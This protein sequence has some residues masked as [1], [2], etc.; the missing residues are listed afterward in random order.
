MEY[1]MM[2]EEMLIYHE[3]TSIE[4]IK[5]SL[6]KMMELD[7]EEKATINGISTLEELKS[8]MEQPEKYLKKTHLEDFRELMELIDLMGGIYF[9]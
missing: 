3:P 6:I 1:K 7:M 4:K 9:A 5:E 2:V 8:F